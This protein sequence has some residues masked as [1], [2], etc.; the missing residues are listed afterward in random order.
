MKPKR[1]QVDPRPVMP[2]G[3]TEFEEKRIA[4]EFELIFKRVAEL[5]LSSLKE[6]YEYTFRSG[7]VSGHLAGVRKQ[8]SVAGAGNAE[9][10]KG[11]ST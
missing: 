9:P 4:C 8:S 6:T 3:E 7:Y 1:K 11:Q 2:R 10:Q 5:G